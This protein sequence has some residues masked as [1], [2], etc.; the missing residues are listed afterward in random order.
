MKGFSCAIWVTWM[1]LR[2][3]LRE[4]V[5]KAIELTHNNHR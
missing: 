4:K 1:P 3:G 2:A 5:L